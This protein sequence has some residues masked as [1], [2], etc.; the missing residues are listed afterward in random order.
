MSQA[1][2]PNEIDEEIL[3]ELETKASWEDE[4]DDFMKKYSGMFVE[5][6]IPVESGLIVWEINKILSR[7]MRVENKLDEVILAL[8][9]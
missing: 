7:L 3:D 8:N 1:Q 2:E 5:R 6:Q 4:L 9:Q